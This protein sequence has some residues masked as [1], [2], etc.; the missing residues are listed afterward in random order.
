[1][2]NLFILV[3]EKIPPNRILLYILFM[4]KSIL[5][6]YVGTSQMYSIKF[7]QSVNEYLNSVKVII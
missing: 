2:F 4:N 3:V 1:M 6:F 5:Y 7:S